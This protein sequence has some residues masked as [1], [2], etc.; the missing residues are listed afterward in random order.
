MSI[1]TV[2]LPC[3]NIVYTRQTSYLLLVGSSERCRQQDNILALP[4]NALGLY[5]TMR[6]FGIS[7]M[8][9][10][11]VRPMLLHPESLRQRARLGGW[12]TGAVGA[13]ELALMT[14]ENGRDQID[15]GSLPA[16]WRAPGSSPA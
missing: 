9:D 5:K 2:P 7:A 4:D 8:F 10:C 13:T 11:R 6:R 16:L 12:L 3:S 1:L 15:T 14:L